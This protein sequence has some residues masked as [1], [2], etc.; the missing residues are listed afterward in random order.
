M[1][2][3]LFRRLSILIAPLILVGAVMVSRSMSA[4]AP[5]ARAENPPELPL[6]VSVV[7][8]QNTE[9]PTTLPIQGELVAYDK[10][11]IFAE[12]AGTLTPTPKAFKVGTRYNKG[13]LMLA[14]DPEETRLNLFAQKSNL[15][16]AITL[17]MPDLKI[18][19]PESF[20]Q[21]K[22]YL[23]QFD[24][25]KPLQPFPK[26]LNEQEKYFI[27]ARN[28]LSQYY[29]IKSAEARLAKFN[30]YAPF[31]GVLTRAN[32]NPGALVSPGQ[33]L[34]ELMN[35]N[36]YE[37]KATVPLK[38]LPYLRTGDR[39]RLVSEDVAGNWTGTVRR[40]STQIDRATQTTQVFIGVT[41]EG[42]R[43]GMY[44]SGKATGKKV[45]G[46]KVPRRLLTGQDGVFV[47]QEDKLAIVPV[48]IE[49][50]EGDSAIVSGLEDG[51]QMLPVVPSGAVVG[52]RVQIARE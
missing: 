46:F 44:L 5:A 38:D 10:I 41:G 16:N 9:L 32:T 50:I 1:K 25:E 2:N 47:V 39:V 29:S 11:Q 23:D 42:L 17:L 33:S 15:L 49:A 31:T 37:L 28:L 40:V 8:V 22:A 48:Q 30:I 13:D 36:R 7:E 26:P 43:E 24:V 20:T 35:P 3:N 51:M 45:K 27:H 19:Y 6:V 18:D 14:I 4:P 34:G 52:K 21:W 12:V